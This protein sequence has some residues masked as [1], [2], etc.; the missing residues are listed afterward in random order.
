MDHCDGYASC[1]PLK[2]AVRILAD[3][4]REECLLYDIDVAISFPANVRTPGFETENLIKH[5]LTL[6][7]EGPAFEESTEDVAKYIIECLDR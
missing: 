7:M 6:K 4:L 5:A 1:A 3:T 2:A